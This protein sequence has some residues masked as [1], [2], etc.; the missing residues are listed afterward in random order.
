METEVLEHVHRDGQNIEKRVVWIWVSYTHTKKIINTSRTMRK[1]NKMKIRI[2]SSSSPIVGIGRYTT[3]LYRA[4]QP[5]SKLINFVTNKKVLPEINEGEIIKGFFPN[6]LPSGWFIN[7]HF[8]KIVYRKKRKELKSETK[9]GAILHYSSPEENPITKKGLSVVTYHD[10][11]PLKPIADLPNSFTK[12]FKT[13][14]KHYKKF[15]N[16]LTVSDYVKNDLQS[17]DFTGNITT[18]YPAV[19]KTFYPVENKD[20]LRD[21]LKLPKDKTLILSVSSTERRKNLITIKKVIEKLDN[22]YK[23]VRVGQAVDNSIT[24]NKIDN[25]LLNK[26]YN[27]CDVLLFPSLEEGF[28]YPVIEAF[29]TGLPVVSSNI[30]VIKEI[31]GD[32]AILINPLDIEEVINGIGQALENKTY[33][34]NKGFERAKMFDFEAFKVRINR[35]Y[36]QILEK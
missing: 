21:E 30:T 35:Y 5:Y 23:L 26:I 10:I 22:N 19:S 31:A 17:I 34:S 15:E 36:E 28:G 9:D 27:A 11:I 18:I 7:H 29:T 12:S 4:T 14:L 25:V 32:S 24:F 1:V 8:I 13:N 2:I 6:F 20:A 16:V 33:F 3:D